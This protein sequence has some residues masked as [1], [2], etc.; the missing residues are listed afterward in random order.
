MMVKML[1]VLDHIVFSLQTMEPD[2]YKKM[3]NR[4]GFERI[5]DRIISFERAK[6]ELDSETLLSV[7]FLAFPENLP[8]K[9]KFIDYWRSHNLEVQIQRLHSWGNKFDLDKDRDNRRYPCPYL[10]LYPTVTHT[11]KL[12]TCFADF[13]DEMAY[14]SLEE[15][16]MESLWQGEK[17]FALREKHL[18]AK[19]GA[20]TLCENCEGFLCMENGFEYRGDRF[21]VKGFD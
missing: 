2:L 17:A 1:S 21:I 3:V 13:Y 9:Q 6:M 19:W 18:N 11:G 8:F 16:S 4:N 5:E 7:Q 15:S 20:I 10:W 14:G 12:A